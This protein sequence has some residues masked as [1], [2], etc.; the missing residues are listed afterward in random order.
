MIFYLLTIL[1]I[2]PASPN[3]FLNFS[4]YFYEMLNGLVGRSWIFDSLVS[5]PYENHLVKSAVIGACFLFA[6]LGTK[7]EAETARRRSILLITIV[8]SVFVIAT[9]KTLSK[10]IFLPRPFIQSQKSFHLEGDQ[11]VES[12][13]LDYRVPLNEESQNSFKALE[14]GEIIQNDLGSFPSDHAGFYLTL[15]VGI[16]LACRFAGLIAVAW[17]ILITLG[18]RIILGQHSPLDIIVGGGIGVVILFAMQ[19]ILGKWGQRFIRPVVNWT[20]K[21]SALSLSFLFIFLLEAVY[22]FDDIRPLIKLGKDIFKS[23]IGGAV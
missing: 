11:L 22:T 14:R 5:L 12:Q 20:L 23:L 13:R 10:T 9:T 19:F 15:A 3:R 2:T 8:A 21:Y 1:M 17:T 6:W 4:D 16:L 18:S 7:N